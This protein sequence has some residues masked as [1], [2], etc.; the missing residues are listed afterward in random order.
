[1]KLKI[2][3]DDKCFR[4]SFDISIECWTLTSC[5]FEFLKFRFGFAREYQL[6]T[7]RIQVYLLEILW[8]SQ[9]KQTS[10]SQDFCLHSNG[11]ACIHQL[12]CT[13]N[14]KT[15]SSTM[16]V[17]SFVETRYATVSVQFVCIILVAC[18]P[19]KT[20]T[21]KHSQDALPSEVNVSHLCKYLTLFSWFF[22]SRSFSLVFHFLV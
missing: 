22:C 9:W 15:L 4:K 12:L 16:F 11:T 10:F 8:K 18:I 7:Q 17:R 13:W 3:F 2:I 14:V 20:T 1:M 19:K 21:H 5:Q 6:R